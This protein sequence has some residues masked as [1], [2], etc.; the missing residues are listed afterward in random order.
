ML[1]KLFSAAFS[2]GADGRLERP[3]G[4][5]PQNLTGSFDDRSPAAAVPVPELSLM[6]N[7]GPWLSKAGERALAYIHWFKTPSN[8]YNH[9]IQWITFSIYWLGF[10][11]KEANLT[12]DSASQGHSATGYTGE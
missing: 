11:N 1:R 10:V 7:D 6:F 9:T 12:Q 8:Y 4:S 3:K 5:G 2:L